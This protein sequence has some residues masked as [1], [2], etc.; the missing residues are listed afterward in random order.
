LTEL[1]GHQGHYGL[2]FTVDSLCVQPYGYYGWGIALQEMRS[3]GAPNLDGRR[4]EFGDPASANYGRRALD[5][6]C[7]IG[8]HVPVPQLAVSLNVAKKLSLA[9]G[10]VAPAAVT[11][12]Q[13]GGSDGTIAV[14]NGARP[15]PTRYEVVRQDVQFAFTATFGAAYKALPWLS[16]G[17]SLQVA[18]ASADVYQVMAL[19]AGTSPSSDM[20]TKIHASDYFVPALLGGVY[21]KPTRNIRIGATLAWSQGIDGSGN[22]TFYTNHYHHGAV[23]DEFIPYENPST[24]IK[25][26]TAPAPLTATLA[27]RYVQ[28]LPGK[29]EDA[30]DP[31]NSEWWDVELDAS[32]VSSG[33]L[34][35]AKASVAE[36]I[37]LQF[38]R[39]DGT[40]ADPLE[41]K[42][43]D[44]SALSADRHGLDVYS[45]RL[46]GSYA[47]LPGMLQASAGGFFQSRGVEAAYVTVDNY[48]LARIGFGLGMRVRLGPV[49]LSAAYS[50]VF[51]ETLELAPPKHEPR[52]QATEADA[53]R[54]F[55][56]RI[57]E[58]GML[59]E[60]PLKDPRAPAI[61][62]AD[63]VAQARQTAGFDSEKARVINAG[64]YTAGFN[65][66]SIAVTHR[67]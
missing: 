39:A 59:T 58:D 42:A 65:V 28:P 47:I 30:R 52:D 8:S 25:R 22:L 7:N 17:L 45:L 61:N 26:I 60:K 37:S 16:F 54:G 51:Q 32:Y 43:S 41:I 56:Q 14:G 40:P 23:D 55:D 35:A 11:G 67:F 48:S 44:L 66:F 1:D 63:A 46:G 31:L 9:L 27:L 6:V 62:N 15:T 19:R 13:W 38:K 57:Y 33:H 49:D 18:M 64:R 36:D 21:A 3:G 2:D 20:M 24:R 29:E 5:K 34:G 10:M 50:H 4:S 53:T 12:M